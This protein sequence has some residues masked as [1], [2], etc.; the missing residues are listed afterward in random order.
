[1]FVAVVSVRHVCVLLCCRWLCRVMP[2]VCCSCLR[3]SLL[4]FV[5][6]LMVSSRDIA[7]FVLIVFV[8][9][10]SFVLLLVL[11][12]Y[13]GRFYLCLSL[14]RLLCSSWFCRVRL[15]ASICNLCLSLIRLLC[16]CWFCRV[17]LC[18]YVCCCVCH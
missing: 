15:G 14:I 12:C 3:L 17:M 6:L 10:A 16:C 5:V 8:I 1:M 2:C 7:L 13:V 18:D 4:C 9:Y 11:S